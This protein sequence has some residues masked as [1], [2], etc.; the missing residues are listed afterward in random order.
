MSLPYFPARLAASWSETPL[1]QG[2]CLQVAPEVAASY[3]HAGQFLKVKRPGETDG[4]FFAIASGPN[5]GDRVELLVKRGEGL[6]DELMEL[7]VGAPL[8]TTL[9]MGAGFP[10]AANRG[11]D[12]LLFATG[13]GIAP[14]RAALQEILAER[15]QWGAI[16]LFFGVRT[17]EDFPYAKELEALAARGIHVHQG[18]AQRP[19]NTGHAR[20]VQEQFRADLPRVDNAVAF[21]CGLQ[22]MVDGVSQALCSCGLPKE[23]IYLNV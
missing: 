7:P 16:D 19:P 11:R 8:E 5:H 17:P 23:R 21:L 18:I 20:Y 22:G 13:S 4:A 14:I 12:V 15:E 10:L 3:R 9:A 2:L 6:P 1:L